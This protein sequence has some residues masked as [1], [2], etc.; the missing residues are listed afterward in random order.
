MRSFCIDSDIHLDAAGSGTTCLA[1]QWAVASAV[2][3]IELL[4]ER[5]A[6]AK[7]IVD[8]SHDPASERLRV[9]FRDDTTVEM[10]T[11]A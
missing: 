6:N 7:Q 5:T 2:G 3:K 11:R 1:N 9:A 10:S 4:S 8:A